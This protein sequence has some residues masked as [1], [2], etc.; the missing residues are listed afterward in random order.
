M[1]FLRL[2]RRKM[3]DIQDVLIIGG[4]Y[5]GM[6]AAL[7][8]GRSRRKVAVLDAGNPCNS[9]T[10]HSH[11]FLTQDGSTPA[12]LARLA[13]EQ[14]KN[15]P[16]VRFIK[17]KAVAGR[18][19]EKGF[20]I[21]TETGQR[22]TGRKLI[23]ATGLKDKMLPVSGFRECWGISVVHC[24]YCHG[25]EIRDQRTAILANGDMAYHLL[26][27][28][29]NLTGTITLL[30]NGPA[31]FTSEQQ[32]HILR[33]SIQVIETALE[34]ILHEDGALHTLKFQDGTTLGLEAMYAKVD[35]T[36]HCSIPAELGCELNAQGLL[37]ADPM[38]RTSVP[39]VFACGDAAAMRSVATAVATGNMAGA[40]CNAELC[41]DTF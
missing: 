34:A 37:Q 5:A 20:E 32:R 33:R 16:T 23:F 29:A 9:Q 25:Y 17:D 3:Q 21:T 10:P 15:Y 1:V 31:A 24:P 11:N 38:Q 2:N 30:T 28:V 19:I 18:A 36:Q 14:V 4:S 41:Q 40:A 8:L 6:S 22:L 13:R 26:Q 12:E 27:L 35:F 7:S 39:G